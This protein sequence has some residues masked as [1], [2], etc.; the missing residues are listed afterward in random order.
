VS[1]WKAETQYSPNGTAAIPSLTDGSTF[2]GDY[3]S[4]SDTWAQPSSPIDLS[5]QT[6]CSV[7]FSSYVDVNAGDAF[8]FWMRPDSSFSTVNQTFGLFGTGFLDP[9]FDLATLGG[10]SLNLRFGLFSDATAQVGY[11]GVYIDDVSVRCVGN[12]YVAGGNGDVRTLNGTS[13]AAPHVAGAAAL[14]LSRN[15]S[16]TTNQLRGVL[17][18]TGDTKPAFQNGVTNTGT[19][20]NLFGAVDAALSPPPPPLSKFV[21]LTPTRILDTRQSTMLA[22]G[23][24]RDLVVTGR[25]GVPQ[26]GVDA[27]LVNLT[28]TN[29][30]ADGYVTTWPKGE[31]KPPTSSLNFAA[32]QTVANLAVAK[33]GANGS[34]SI[35]NTGDTAGRRSVDVIVD[36]VGYFPTSAMGAV[37]P[38]RLLDTRLTG[39]VAPGTSVRLPVLGRSGVPTTGV[40]AVILNLTATGASADGYLT[41]WPTGETKPNASSLNF[42]AGQTVA[43]LVVA[44]IG[45]DG[46]ISIWNSG[47]SS[48]MRNVHV[49][50][51]VVGW[52]PEGSTFGSLLPSRLLD[53]RTFGAYPPSAGLTMQLS[54]LGR[55]GVPTSGVGAV[56]LNLTAT[57]AKA[58]GYLTI[59]PTGS[60]YPNTS[61]LNFA[62]GQTV[63]NL[64]VAKVGADGTI[65]IWNSNDSPSMGSVHIIVDVVGWFAA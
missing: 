56:V 58:D 31:A 4:N 30:S 61:S 32:G 51:D 9:T 54:V 45:A 24:T 48:D 16:L 43:N 14:A 34:I 5:G 1:T 60:A 15:A 64:V 44:K 28:V 7:S 10:T 22:A 12:S 17:L 62:A 47:D 59:W 23:A 41:T 27:V 39:A 6:G 36:V 19:R 55:G 49:I 11:D 63:A 20:L 53:T 50:A 21:S 57:A 42:A 25:A 37:S 65:M 2:V 29:T 33:V 13:F 8:R 38:D 3:P 18:A 46:S 40:G 35:W 52:L 26:Q